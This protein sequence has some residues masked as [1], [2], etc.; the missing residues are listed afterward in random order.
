MKNAVITWF[1]NQKLQ[2]KFS[3]ILL[4]ALLLMFLGM[5][6]TSTM[7]NQAYN[8]AL[9]ERTVQ[10]LTLF[11]Q[12]VQ[13]ELESIGDFSFSIIADNV[14]QDGLTQLHKNKVGSQ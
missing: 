7:T 8:D 2:I 11:A 12:N 3:I 14:I 13:E 10:L 6:G 1:R 9:Y 4:F 5:L